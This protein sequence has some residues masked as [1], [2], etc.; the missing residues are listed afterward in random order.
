[1]TCSFHW[2][3]LNTDFANDLPA[4]QRQDRQQVQQRPVDVD[5]QQNTEE[6]VQRS[7]LIEA[8][9]GNEQPD[10]SRPEDQL[11]RWPGGVDEDS[12]PAAR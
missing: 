4:V 1:M 8:E 9:P 2:E 10:Q 7:A 6:E 11:N 3:F 5:V 12:L